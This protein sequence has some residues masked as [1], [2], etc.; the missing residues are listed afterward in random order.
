MVTCFS[1]LA[2]LRDTIQN[3]AIRSN[4]PSKFQTDIVENSKTIK[5][6]W[7]RML[8]QI[9]YSMFGLTERISFVSASILRVWCLHSFPFNNT[10]SRNRR[11]AWHDYACDLDN[12]PS[13]DLSLEKARRQIPKHDCPQILAKIASQQSTPPQNK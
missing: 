13:W 6:R 9:D 4:N 8:H 7:L 12:W 1:S 3:N 10:L 2:V 5:H 11:C